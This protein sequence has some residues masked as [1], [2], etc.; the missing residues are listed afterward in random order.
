MMTMTK[1]GTMKPNERKDKLVIKPYQSSRVSTTE[2]ATVYPFVEIVYLFRSGCND[3]DL[4]QVLMT[5]IGSACNNLRVVP[6]WTH[7]RFSFS[8]AVIGMQ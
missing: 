2:R 8:V 5:V 6:T 3:R 7:R 1:M 4:C